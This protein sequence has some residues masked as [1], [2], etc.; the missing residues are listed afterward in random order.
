MVHCN[1]KLT[2]K[3]V[4]RILTTDGRTKLLKE[5]LKKLGYV[6]MQ[7]KYQKLWRKLQILL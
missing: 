3:E 2:A 4:Q 6:K 5:K 7:N 1:D